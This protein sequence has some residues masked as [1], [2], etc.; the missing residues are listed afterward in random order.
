[1]SV[2]I[3]YVLDKSSLVCR[4][5][6]SPMTSIIYQ[7]SENYHFYCKECVNGN[8]RYKCIECDSNVHR[9][10]L[11]EHQIKDQLISCWRGG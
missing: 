5:C 3:A 9:N 10:K 8:K 6:D 4:M 7:C 2:T 11:M 1:M